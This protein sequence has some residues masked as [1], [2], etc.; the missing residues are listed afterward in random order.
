MNS[1]PSARKAEVPLVSVRGRK[2]DFDNIRLYV[3]IN[4]F[5]LQFLV[6][7]KRT[8]ECTA[9]CAFNASDYSNLNLNKCV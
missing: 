4:S 5:L 3:S 2:C 1:Q 7:S 6:Q 9:K 8:K